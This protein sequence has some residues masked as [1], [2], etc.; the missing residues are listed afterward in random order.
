MAIIMVLPDVFL[1]ARES[2]VSLYEA[3]LELATLAFTDNGKGNSQRYRLA[4]DRIHESSAG[5]S[6]CIGLMDEKIVRHLNDLDDPRNEIV[7]FR[8]MDV[9][10]H[11][12]VRKW[13]DTIFVKVP[14]APDLHGGYNAVRC[15]G[16]FDEET[17]KVGDLDEVEPVG[18]DFTAKTEE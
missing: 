5:R 9:G 10:Q 2:G 11:M 17:L 15:T 18:A 1:E 8:D 13:G 16:G 6:Y 7:R 12:R 4:K 14:M 3:C